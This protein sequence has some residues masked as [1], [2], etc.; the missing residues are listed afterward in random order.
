MR[1]MLQQIKAIA[2]RRRVKRMRQWVAS[3]DKAHLLALMLDS[4]TG[5]DMHDCDGLVQLAFDSYPRGQKDAIIQR[6]AEHLVP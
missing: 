4:T 2:R 1:E 5:L 3:L 6:I